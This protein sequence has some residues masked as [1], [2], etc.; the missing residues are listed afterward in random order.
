MSKRDF[1]NSGN[2]R[3]NDCI[4]VRHETNDS[5]FDR[6]GFDDSTNNNRELI[7]IPKDVSLAN[8]IQSLGKMSTSDNGKGTRNSE[9]Y[10]LLQFGN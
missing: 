5:F 1:H 2:S 7:S 6:Y 3:N 8:T 9:D 10:N 4:K